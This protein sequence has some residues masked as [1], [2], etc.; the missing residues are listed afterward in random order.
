MKI[1][2][3]IIVTQISFTFMGIALANETLSTP[4]V[5]P[6]RKRRPLAARGELGWNGLAGIGVNLTYNFTPRISLDYGSG[7]SINGW[8][9]GIRGRYNFMN[10]NWTPFVGIGLLY[11]SGFGGTINTDAKREPDGLKEKVEFRNSASAFI[12]GVTGIDYVTNFGLTFMVSVGYS[13]V[14]N[15]HLEYVSGSKE[16]YEDIKF[17]SNSGVVLSTSVGYAFGHR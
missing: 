9:N 1:L 6:I 13:Q 4:E 5:E 8:K 17:F 3:L 2:C 11:C 14:L 12:Q 10:N 15:N 16:L 7:L